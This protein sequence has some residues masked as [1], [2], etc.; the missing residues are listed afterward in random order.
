M[1]PSC[2]RGLMFL[3]ALLIAIGEPSHAAMAQPSDGL[4]LKPIEAVIRTGRHSP[5]AKFAATLKS[6]LSACAGAPAID[7]DALAGKIK[8]DFK[9]AIKAAVACGLVPGLPTGSLAAEGAITEAVWRAIM[10]GVPLPSLRDRLE[11]LVLAFEATDFGEAP[12]WNFCQDS[13]DKTRDPTAAGFLCQNWSDPC[14]FLTWGPRGATAGAGREIQ[15][16]LWLTWRARPELVEKALG[17]EFKH[18]KRFIRLKGEQP[19]GSCNRAPLKLFLC[20]IWVDPARRTIWEKALAGLSD[21]ETVRSVYRSVYALEEFDGGRLR[22]Y[23]E[24]W[25]RLELTPSEVDF[26]FFF[27]RSTHYGGPFGEEETPENFTSLQSCVAGQKKGWS[28]NG[29]ARRCLSLQQKHAAQEANRLGRDVAFYIDSFPDQFLT[30]A[31]IEAWA[32]YLPVSAVHSFGFSETRP[33]PLPYTSS[34]DDLRAEDSLPTLSEVTEA[35][36]HACPATVIDPL[37]APQ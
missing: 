33:V 12:E 3:V 29:K 14:S 13:P 22:A 24:L 10:G 20:S 2:L 36:R 31:E 23:Y 21:N 25:Q 37:S 28:D 5:F 4:L 16:I 34:T 17:S 6:K 30:P 15:W 11:S 18:F 27:D 32:K 1:Y 35:E 26:A 9:E 19:D 8:S 7:D